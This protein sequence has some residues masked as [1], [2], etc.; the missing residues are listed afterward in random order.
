MD[1]QRFN[2]AKLKVGIDVEEYFREKIQE[3]RV[4]NQDLIS[5]NIQK[6]LQ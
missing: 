5:T 4:K 6:Y 1:K 2:D 3:L